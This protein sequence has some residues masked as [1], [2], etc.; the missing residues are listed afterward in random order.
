MR[1]YLYIFIEYLIV[2]IKFVVGAVRS[3]FIQKYKSFNSTFN[4]YIIFLL[5]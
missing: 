2:Y 3:K 5:Y 1:T 4:V